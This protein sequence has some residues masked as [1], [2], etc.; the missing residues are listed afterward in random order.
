MKNTE[1]GIKSDTK[2]KKKKKT[3]WNNV[4]LPILAQAQTQ[5]ST[6]QKTQEY[7]RSMK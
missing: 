3:S 1:G 2:P 6:R 4:F 5:G 7:N